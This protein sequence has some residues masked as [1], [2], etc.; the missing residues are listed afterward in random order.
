MDKTQKQSADVRRFWFLFS[1]MSLKR[2][3]KKTLFL[4]V[5]LLSKQI[6]VSLRNTLMLHL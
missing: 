5:C 2:S 1:Q 4:S 3:C 6:V